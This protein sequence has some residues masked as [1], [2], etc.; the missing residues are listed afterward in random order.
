MAG[1]SAGTA[2]AA[3]PVA[4]R[5][6]RATRAG[7][8][9]KQV[10]DWQTLAD[11]RLRWEVG[12]KPL[13][14]VVTEPPAYPLVLVVLEEPDPDILLDPADRYHLRRYWP[15]PGIGGWAC[16]ADGVRVPLAAVWSWLNDPSITA[17]NPGCY[18]VYPV[19]AAPE[20]ATEPPP[21]KA[22]GRKTGR[23]V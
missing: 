9:L 3:G 16:S 15:V 6:T 12:L 13:S 1:N 17:T 23:T 18:V 19:T 11:E 2:G 8:L 14:V 5:A 21:G 7:Q 4:T 10:P 20:A 22:G